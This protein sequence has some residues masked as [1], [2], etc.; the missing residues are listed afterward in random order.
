MLVE[1][2]YPTS[3]PLQ[4]VIPETKRKPKLIWFETGLVNYQ[5]GIRKEIIGAKEILDVWKGR[6]AEQI[7]AQELLALSDKVGQKRAFWSRPNNGA[8]VDFI[9]TYDSSIYPI[10][11]KNGTNAHLRS[12]QVFM[13]Q[14]PVELAIRIWSGTYSVDHLTTPKGKPFQLINLPFYLIGRLN[15]IL[16][17]F[18]NS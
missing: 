9:H 10:E 3:S 15:E 2:V 6:I 7:V 14:S 17:L 16:H 4:P 12:I 13:D 5:A 1:L 18:Q 11:V 8:E